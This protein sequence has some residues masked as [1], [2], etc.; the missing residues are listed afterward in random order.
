G[1][2][3]AEQVKGRALLPHPLHHLLQRLVLE[4]LPRLYRLGDAQEGLHDDTSG[5]EIQ[6]SNLG[7]AHL[8]LGK[9]DRSAM[10]DESS[11]WVAI[12]MELV[13][14]GRGGDVDSIIVGR[15]S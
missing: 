6:V 7:V 14:H 9:A 1:A 12:R 11:A 3:E 15:L 2:D 4:E 13:P 10:G 5:A 8:A